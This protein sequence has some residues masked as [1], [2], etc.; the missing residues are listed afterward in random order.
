MVAFVLNSLL[1]FPKSKKAKIK[2]ARDFMLINLIFFPVVWGAA[3]MLEPIC[4]SFGFGS[5]SEA[6]AHAIAISLPTLI[7]FL[8]YKLFAFKDIEYG[9]K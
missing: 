1:V 4:Y 9:R 3:L 5:Y 8:L 7:T 2:Q 6:I